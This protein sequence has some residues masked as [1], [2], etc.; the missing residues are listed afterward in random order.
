MI[1]NEAAFWRY[2]QS[3]SS[4]HPDLPSTRVCR[5]LQLLFDRWQTKPRWLTEEQI[6]HLVPNWESLSREEKR[7]YA[8]TPILIR[9]ARAVAR[10]LELVTNGKIASVADTNRINPDELIVGTLPPFSVGQGKEFVRYLTPAEA[11]RASL[12]YLNELSPM[13]HIVPDHGRLLERGLNGLIA[14]CRKRVKESTPEQSTF[15]EAVSICLTAVKEYAETYAAQADALSARYED[16]DPRC[17]NLRQVAVNL[18]Q[19]PSNPPQTFRQAVQA[20]Y[21]L[22]CAFHWT[23]EIV[24]LGRLDQNPRALLPV[25]VEEPDERK[26][27]RGRKRQEGIPP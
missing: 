9:K 26:A 18:R 16:G 24:P 14:D 23:V 4:D 11:H 22:H 7:L 1:H 27:W 17:E 21:L 2:L 25:R 5:L 10:M 3:L 6:G 20:V 19:A 12:S 15:F 8:E 13:G